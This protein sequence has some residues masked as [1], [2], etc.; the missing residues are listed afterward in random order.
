MSGTQWGGMGERT[1][2]SN[3]GVFGERPGMGRG[4]KD[5]GQI[6]GS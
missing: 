2:L 6:F 5:D 1:L 4:L 3:D